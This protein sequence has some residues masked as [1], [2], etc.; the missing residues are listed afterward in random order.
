MNKDVKSDYVVNFADPDS[1]EIHLVGGKAASLGRMTQGGFQIPPG[2][3][4]STLGYSLFME[5]NGIP[6]LIATVLPQINYLDPVALETLTE[7]IRTAIHESPIPHELKI[8]ILDGYHSLGRDSRVA[9]RS[10]GTAEDLAEASFA[11]LHDTYLDIHG[12]D[13]ILNHVRRCWASMWTARSTS[14]RHHGGFD[15]TSSLLAVTIQKM[16][17]SEVAGV[18]FTANPLKVRTDEFV[19][20]ASWG[21]GESVVSGIITPDEFVVDKT[22]GNIKTRILG[23]KEFQ[24]VHNKETGNGT[25]QMETSLEFKEIFSLSDEQVTELCRLGQK[26][27]NYYGGIPQDI[28]WALSE[29]SFYLLQSR[30]I[31]GV[32]FT[33]DEDVDGWQTLPVPEETVWSH[34]FADEFWTGAITPLFYSIRAKEVHDINMDDF[35]RWGFEDLSEMRWLK[36]FE[37]TAY[38]NANGDRKYDEYLFPPSLRGATLSKIPPEWRAEAASAPFDVVKGVFTQLRM[39][40]LEPDRGLTRWFDEVNHF[41]KNEIPAADGPSDIELHQMSDKELRKAI[42]ATLDLAFRFIGLLRPAFHYYGVLVPGLLNRMVQLWY[43]GENKFIFQ[44]LISGLPRPTMTAEEI[45]AVWRTALQIKQSP[46]LTNL[47][48]ANKG[49]EFFIRLEESEEGREFLEFYREELLIPHGHRGH[50][51][52]DLWYKRRI[53][54]YSLDYEAFR[55]FLEASEEKTPEDLEHK[56]IIKRE[57]A[58]REMISSI[59]ATSFATWKVAGFKLLLDYVLKFLMIRDDERHYIDRATFAK[60]RL[61]MEVGRRLVERK[62]LEQE[63]DFYFLAHQEIEEVWQGKSSAPLVRLKISNRRRVFERHLARSA[64]VAP[65][66]SEDGSIVHLD[67]HGTE[68]SSDGTLR[69]VGV[70]RGFITA[71]ARV[72]KDLKDIGRV[73]KGEILICNSTDPGWASIFAIISGLVMETGGMLAHG[74]CLSREYGLPAVT[75]RNAMSIIEDGETITVSGDTGEILRPQKVGLLENQ[76]SHDK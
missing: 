61:F 57:A 69:G 22:N 71:T 50:A 63:D 43:R 56:L 72:V 51:D 30:N 52:R 9:I 27:M 60:K 45:R 75:L 39:L 6:N 49:L 55:S 40:F 74:S 46:F 4:I 66:I 70:S 11:G 31:T 47:F 8:A 3:T 35:E 33:W 65:F 36:W 20:N 17:T 38:Y 76:G 2:L 48:Y 12:D 18:L 54:D 24:I 28:E 41:M 7:K 37:G 73:N 58:T 5:S 68:D 29:G 53:E 59:E 44:E 64:L 23:S 34:A 62:L 42:K 10:S 26:V 13:E 14:Y 15:H 19:V 1:L 25:V 16:V 67:E 21:L 32:E